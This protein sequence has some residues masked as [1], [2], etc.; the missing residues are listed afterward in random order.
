E[1]GRKEEREGKWKKKGREGGRKEGGKGREGRK[2]ER[3]EGRKG[4][5]EEGRKQG[6]EREGRE[7]GRRKGKG[8]RKEIRKEGGRERNGKGREGEKGRRKR[9]KER[10]KERKKERIVKELGGKLV[11]GER[12]QELR[13]PGRHINRVWEAAEGRSGQEPPAERMDGMKTESKGPADGGGSWKEPLGHLHGREASLVEFKRKKAWLTGDPDGGKDLDRKGR[14]GK[15]ERERK[16]KEKKEE[17]KSKKREREKGKKK[18]KEK[19]EK[20][21][22]E[23]RKR[24]E[25][26]KREKERK[27]EKKKRERERKKEKERKRKREKERKKERKRRKEGRKEGRKGKREGRKDG[28]KEREKGGKEGREGGWEEGWEIR[29]EGRMVDAFGLPWMV[30]QTL[31]A[32]WAKNSP[33]PSFYPAALTTRPYVWKV[34]VCVHAHVPALIMHCTCAP[35]PPEHACAIPLCITCL[36]AC[37]HVS[38]APPSLVRLIPDNQLAGG[39]STCVRSGSVPDDGLCASRNGSLCHFRHSVVVSRQQSS[40][41][42]T[43]DSGVRLQSNGPSFKK[44]KASRESDVFLQE[45]KTF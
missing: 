37:V 40:C 41:G 29:K 10:K 39:R 11:R 25:I 24:K 3:E 26:G 7:E 38:R 33:L 30:C 4:G 43:G 8:G 35:H 34:C 6:N 1:G 2:E 13:R 20:G 19:R 27:K 22:K 36:C 14:G 23:G 45:A 32:D 12:N 42:S 21:R 28:R 15:K 9:E 18:E 5:R 44:I 31:P 17:R 16:E